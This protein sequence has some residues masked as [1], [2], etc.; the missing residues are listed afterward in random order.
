LV[1][2]FVCG[3]DKHMRHT[4]RVVMS[5]AYIFFFKKEIRLKMNIYQW[6]KDK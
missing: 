5:L 2:K 6:I 4:D 3:T 1:Q